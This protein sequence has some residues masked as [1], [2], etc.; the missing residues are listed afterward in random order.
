MQNIQVRFTSQ[1]TF[2]DSY[3]W[4]F[5]DGNTSTEANPVHTYA[6]YGSRT[7]T[8][9]AISSCGNV[10]T[11]RSINEVAGL[12]IDSELSSRLNIFPNPNAGNFTFSLPNVSFSN[13]KVEILDLTGKSVFQS[14][15]KNLDNQSIQVESL[16]S[17]VYLFKLYVDGKIALKR[18][19]IQ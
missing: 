6:D 14:E 15:V 18:L 2:V 9:T 3:S 12:N 10:S 5:G 1:G 8:L 17:G 4:N 16:E 13:A 19:V 7:V 11:S